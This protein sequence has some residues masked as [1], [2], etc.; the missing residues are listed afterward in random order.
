MLQQPATAQVQTDLARQRHRAPVDRDEQTA[1]QQPLHRARRARQGE[2][3]VGHREVTGR[4]SP[5]EAGQD[6]A[7]GL[8]GVVDQC[9]ETPR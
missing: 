5:G 6:L 4:W 1:R 3:P 2:V 8:S 9:G 7:R